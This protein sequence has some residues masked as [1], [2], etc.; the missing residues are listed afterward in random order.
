MSTPKVTLYPRAVEAM[1]GGTIGNINTLRLML[2]SSA[3][4]PD[5]TAHRTIA[6]VVAHQIEGPGYVAGGRSVPNAAATFVTANAH[7]RVRANATQYEIGAI[8]RPATGNSRIYVCDVPGLSGGAIPTYPTGI[9]DRVT[10]GQVTWRC[11]GMGSIRVTGDPVVWTGAAF[12]FRW[13]ALYT[14]DTNNL[15]GSVDYGGP[16]NL[17]GDAVYTSAWDTHEGITT[18][19]VIIL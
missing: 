14:S 1:F 6:D 10:D 18:V 5:L 16:F 13:G 3:H 17:S 12:G 11:V 19:P 15:W 9:G 2:L 4:L 7:P 8:V